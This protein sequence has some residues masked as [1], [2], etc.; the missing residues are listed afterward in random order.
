M[1]KQNTL[2][3][4]IGSWAYAIGPYQ[5][6]PI[7]LSD[8][9]QRL[10][11]LGFDGVELG[12][13]KPHA[14][15]DLYPGRRE[16]EKLVEMLRENGLGVPAYAADLWS[17]PFAEGNPEVIKRYREFFK[18]S[19][20]FCVD[21]EIPAIRVDTVTHTPPPANLD[22][23][24]AWKRVKEMFSWCS[25]IAGEKDL[26]VVWEFEPGFIINK[27][28]E[29]KKM[30]EE[31]GRENFKILFDT[32]HAHMCSVQAAKQTPP[33]DKLEGGAV[34]FAGLL[35]GKIGHVHVIDSDNTLHDNETS[36]HAPLGEG[37][38][39]FKTLLPAIRDAGYTSTWWS[40]DLCFWPNAWEIT[41]N[42]KRY[43]D[44]LFKELGW[45]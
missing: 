18:R 6:N 10:H 25:D 36:T 37:V 34:E 16:R 30:V 5:D 45:R 20:D 39:D 8:V 40:I 17:L 42:C 2:K 31:V 35:Q 27:P 9:V 7:P 26:L 21:C 1:G 11:K 33:L 23:D 32:C 29:V 44:N 13:F 38:L 14:H 22:P 4:S 24:V 43:L 28:H 19:V 15:P 12:G 41:E 3:I